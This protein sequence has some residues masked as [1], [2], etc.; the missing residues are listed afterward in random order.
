MLSSS[1]SLFYF[2]NMAQL[3]TP[4]RPEGAGRRFELQGRP[5]GALN[6]TYYCIIF[7]SHL[8]ISY[9]LMDHKISIY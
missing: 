1:Y 9:Y 3:G 5:T 4:L 2:L 8:Y 6:E 7:I